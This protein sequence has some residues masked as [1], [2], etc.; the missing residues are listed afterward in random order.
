MDNTGS[1]SRDLPL[2]FVKGILVI[3]MVIYHVMNYFSTA[4]PEDFGHIRFVSGSF[5]FI[6]GYII[7]I[8]YENKYRIDKTGTSKR[9]VLRG[10][11]LLIIFTLL[12]ILINLTGIGNPNKAPLGVQQYLNN[13]TAIYALGNPRFAAFLILLPISYILMISPFFLFF[14]R[15]KKFLIII[16]SITAF[17]FSFLHINSNNLGLGI[18]GL[19]GLAV[20]MIINELERSFFIKSRAIIFCCLLISVC[21]M[22]YLS[23]NVMTYSIGIMIVLKLFCDFGKTVNLRNQINQIIILFGQYSLVCYITQIVFLQGLFRVLPNQRWGLGYE[24]ISIFIIT[25][26]FL[27]GSCSLLN[28]LRGHYESIARAYRLIFS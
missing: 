5:I 23:N 25:N 16:I 17:C 6:S 24:T 14:N 15:S 26:I 10:F 1:S 13:L 3:I 9:L 28:F 27:L 22:G 8:F 19:I 18:V 12:N 21:L 4:S 7:A 2:D 11:K 20:G